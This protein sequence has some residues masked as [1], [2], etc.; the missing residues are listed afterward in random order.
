MDIVLRFFNKK[1]ILCLI[2]GV[3][4]TITLFFGGVSILVYKTSKVTMA[5]PTNNLPN[6]QYTNQPTNPFSTTTPF[7]VNIDNT[8]VE[9]G[10]NDVKQEVSDLPGGI[11]GKF[12]S[13]IF[14]PIR[15]ALLKAYKLTI[16]ATNDIFKKFSINLK[17]DNLNSSKYNVAK[18]V[19]NALKPMGYS[20]LALFFLISFLKKAMYFEMMEDKA[21]YKSL[22]ILIFGKEMIDNSYLLLNG[23]VQLNNQ[24]VQVV[25]SAVGSHTDQFVKYANTNVDSQNSLMIIVCILINFLYLAL[26]ILTILIAYVM[27][28][29][30]QIEMGI[31][32]AVAPLFFSTSCG[33]STM[34]VFKSFI[35]NFITVVIQ[36]VW[37]AIAFGFLTSDLLKVFSFSATGFF[38]NF[39]FLLGCIA[40]ALFCLN[41]PSSVK[42]AIGG[43]GGQGVSLGSLISVIK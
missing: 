23:I 41:A 35:K 40:L 20:L 33:E 18:T 8:N 31:L 43:T 30:R 12:F 37:L 2:I 42:S 16:Q 39:N 29:M 10:L 28:I 26:V 17:N 24:I 36:T 27:L 32:V 9:H 22:I 14:K 34:E 25:L 11:V 7:T 6:L 5:E 19:H 3:I 13:D 21:I 15:N 1:S 38:T 4:V